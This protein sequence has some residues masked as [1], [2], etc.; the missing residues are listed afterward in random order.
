MDCS[1]NPPVSPFSKGGSQKSFSL[2][3]FLDTP[4][5]RGSEQ[6]ISVNHLRNVG[7]TIADHRR[8]FFVTQ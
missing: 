4:V 8:P 3:A 7:Q 1:E 5:R 6:S 2:A